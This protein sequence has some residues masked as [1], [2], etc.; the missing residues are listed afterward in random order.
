MLESYPRAVRHRNRSWHLRAVNVDRRG[1]LWASSGRTKAPWSSNVMKSTRSETGSGTAPW[2]LSLQCLWR[3]S[4][5][6]WWKHPNCGQDGGTEELAL[7][8]TTYKWYLIVMPMS[9]KEVLKLFL[10]SGWQVLRQRGSHVIVGKNEKRETI[11][12]HKELKTGLE[13]ALLKRL[14]RKK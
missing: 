7:T 10:R 1:T 4:N 14:D 6:R 8:N 3:H 12:M 9:G 2:T 13:R 11:P 5:T